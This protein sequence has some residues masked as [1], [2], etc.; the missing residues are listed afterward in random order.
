MGLPRENTPNTEDHTFC[1]AEK[2]ARLRLIRSE[3][4]GP[5]TFFRLLERFG[6]A[7]AAL[8]ALPGL[9]RNGGRAK[10]LKICTLHEAEDEVAELQAMGADMLFHGAAGYP[11]LL[12]YIED[13]PPV[14]FVRGHAHLLNKKAVAMVGSRNAS[15]NGRHF[16]RDMAAHLGQAGYLV[17]SGTARGIDTAAH[18]GS[19]AGGGATVAVMAGGVDIVYPPENDAL[20]QN[21]IETGAIVCEM[22]PGLKP[23]ARHF[24]R[25]NRI[26]SGLSLAIIVVEAAQRSGSLIT[27]RLAGEQGRAVLAVPGS[28]LDPRAYGANH[29][30]R[31]GA[32][33]VRNAEDVFEAVRP[34]ATTPTAPTETPPPAARTPVL[35]LDS[36]GTDSRK[37][38][39][40]CLS[41]EPVAV[42]EIVRRCQ[43]TAPVVRTILLELELAGRLERHPGNRVAAC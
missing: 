28:P 29:L 4:I 14:L 5:V 26:V 24:P 21:I 19:I 6:N 18:A 23:Q 43:L 1:D 36:P 17:V 40:S 32:V 27:A 11:P 8:D 39:I 30:I 42:D 12:T 15:I 25:R 7:R 10:A 22:P 9:A 2:L 38:V 41:P 20:Y 16:A 34:M 31:E 3:N 33:L 13:A 35:D 37:T